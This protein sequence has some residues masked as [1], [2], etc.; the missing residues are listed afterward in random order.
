MYE[1]VVR[2][3]EQQGIQVNQLIK[4]KHRGK[5]CFKVIH[6]GRRLFQ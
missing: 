6:G 2:V 4:I 3:P 1:G 5:D